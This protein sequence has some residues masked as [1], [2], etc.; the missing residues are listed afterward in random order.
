VLFLLLGSGVNDLPK[1]HAQPQAD[2]NVGTA[3]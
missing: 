1:V 2:A 3:V